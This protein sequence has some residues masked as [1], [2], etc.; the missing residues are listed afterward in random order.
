MKVLFWEAKVAR[1]KVFV[2]SIAVASALM[3]P[4]TVSAA[5]SDLGL[6]AI[7]NHDWAAAEIQLQAGLQKEPANSFLQLNLAWVYAQTG[8]KAEAAA[9][10]QEILRRDQD[11]VASLSGQ[12]GPPVAVL[13]KRGLDRLK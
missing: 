2:L 3:L 11:R 8:R 7:Q 13:A 1:M 10:Y 12:V 9:L 6:R 5:D 4:Q